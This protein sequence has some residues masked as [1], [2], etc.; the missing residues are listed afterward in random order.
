MIGKGSLSGLPFPFGKEQNMKL[1]IAEKKS[2]GEAIAAA[3]GVKD[4]EKGYMEGL[5]AIVS[6][7]IGHVVELALPSAYNERFHVWRWD[8]LPI[9]PGQWLYTVRGHVQ[10]QYKVLAEL[11]NR[12]D[13]DT[14]VCATDAGREGELIFRLLYEKTGCKKHV[15][16]LWISSMSEDAIRQGFQRMRPGQDYDRLY[17][18]ALCRQKADWMIGINASRIFSLLYS[19]TLVV[20]RVMTPTLAMIVEREEVISHFTP[21]RFYTVD[22]RCGF[23][24]SSPRLNSKEEAEMIAALCQYK[25]ATVQHIE[26]KKRTEKPPKLYDLTAL[27]RDANRLFGYSAQQ[28]LDYTQ[29]LYE[30]RLVTYPRTDSR[31]LTSDMEKT[32]PQLVQAV[33]GAFLFISGVNHPV[34]PAQV[35]DDNKVSDHHAIIPTLDMTRVDLASLPAGQ[36]DILQLIVMRLLTAVG[37]DHEYEDTIITVSCEGTEFTAHE[38]KVTKM[39]WKTP[40]ALFHGSLGGRAAQEQ[41]EETFHIP[42]LKEGQELKP[43]MAVV[44]EGKTTPPQHFT[45]GTLLAAM[46]TA[47]VED[48]PED[49]ERKG[50]G[51]PATRAGIIESLIKEKQVERKGHGKVQYL[52]PTKLGQGL[53]RIVPEMFKSP[54]M[55][56]EWEQRLKAIEQGREDPDAFLRDVDAMLRKMYETE[57]TKPGMEQYFDLNYESIGNCPHCGNRVHEIGKLHVWKCQNPR[58]HFTLW[59]NSRY[60]SKLG[61]ELTREIAA[62]LVQTRQVALHN[63]RSQKTGREYDAVILMDTDEAGNAKFSMTFP[64]KNAKE[65]ER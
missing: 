33:S 58:C 53:I 13:V 3:I 50:L 32:L 31:Y 39:G 22:L 2:V 7:C 14:I 44:K 21:E 15:Q 43:V 18:A 23:I 12:P 27:Q 59:Q 54:S 49:A 1:I 57:K 16:R 5:N 51:T 56:A 37:D 20:G 25:T 6:W 26:K 45:E 42:D 35:I 30:S 17:A 40:E 55:T 9:L 60:F 8:D 11:M 63:L 10:E 48:L 19:I 46:E 4:K 41:K 36:M 29:A 24:A 38:K 47:G 52:I 61:I 34:H 62:S 28:T 64:K 65:K